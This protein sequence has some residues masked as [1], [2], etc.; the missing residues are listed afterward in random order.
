MAL[1][2]NIRTAEVGFA[3][4]LMALVTRIGEARARRAVYT[5]TLRELN[6]LTT[7]ELNDLGI[8]RSM[9]T[10]VAQDAAYGN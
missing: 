9:I 10:R 1:A 2:Q 5:Q 7:R 4:R 3:D 8:S 6:A